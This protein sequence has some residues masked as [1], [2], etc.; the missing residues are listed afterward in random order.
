MTLFLYNSLRL[1]KEPIQLSSSNIVSMYCCGVTVY[2]HCHL[3]H[4]R[5]YTI[6]DLLA[7]VLKF[8]GYQV[9]YARNITDIDDKIIKKA[10]DNKVSCEEIASKYALSM[11][12]VLMLLGCS[13]PDVEPTAVGAIPKI[14]SIIQQLIDKKNA[15]VVDGEVFFDIDSFQD[16]GKLSHQDL[17]QVISGARVDVDSVKKNPGDFT[18]WKPSKEDEPSWLSPWGLGRPGWHIECSAMIDDVFG[19]TI[20]FH[21]GGADL[22]FP[23]HENEIAQSEACFARPLAKYWVHG[24]FVTVD[25]VKM[26]K[27]LG[28]FHYLQDVINEFGSNTV[29]YFYLTTHY[30]QPLA[31]THDKIHQAKNSWMSIQQTLSPYL[32]ISGEYIPNFIQPLTDALM[33]DLNT[34][35]MIAHLHQLLKQLSKVSE[36]T[37]RNYAFTLISWMRDVLG[38]I[39]TPMV[40]EELPQEIIK[41]LEKRKQARLDKNFGLSDQIRSEISNLGYLVQDLPTGQ[42]CSKKS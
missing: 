4:G 36:D 32:N 18:L 30:R 42:E 29:R 2:D 38:L 19:E 7:R 12:N 22:K 41:L 16:Y 5:I 8:L 33:D 28:N 15:Y 3:G 40:K 13:S 31:F 21:L 11:Q 24:G 35:L 9:K 27:S 6:T 25:D 26:S 10:K 17:S 1:E 34:P 37:S 39:V 20:D 14:I 23:H